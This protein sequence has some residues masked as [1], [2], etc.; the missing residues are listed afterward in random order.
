MA[1]AMREPA[2]MAAL[3][4]DAVASVLANKA[5]AQKFAD[6]AFV[7]ALHDP[8]ISSALRSEAAARA[9]SADAVRKVVTSDAMRQAVSSGLLGRALSSEAMTR[10]L[11]NDV[12][13]TRHV[14]AEVRRRARQLVLTTAGRGQTPACHRR[15]TPHTTHGTLISCWHPCEVGS[16]RHSRC[17]VSY[18]RFPP[19]PNS[20]SSPCRACN[21]CI[22]IRCRPFSCR[23]PRERFS[24]RSHFRPGLFDFHPK[25]PVLLLLTDISDSGNAAASTVPRDVV[26]VEIA[27]LSF[28]FETISGNERMNILMNHELVHIATMDQATGPDRFFRSLFGGKVVPVPEQPESILYFLLTSPRVASPRWYHEGIAVFVD[29][30]MSGGLGR[31]QSGYDEM[32]F[33]SMVRD[34]T[35][36]F[37][38]LGLVSA[39][40][41]IDFQTQVNSYLYGTRFMTW[42]GRHYSPEKVIEWVSRRDG[43][44]AYYAAQFKHVFGDSAR[45]GMGSMGP[46]GARVPAGQPRTDSHNSR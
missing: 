18:L 12:F 27:P 3:H 6:P 41:Q 39:G 28:A 26:T 44:R 42:L 15:Q 40:T 4:S 9:F 38:P 29:T 8:A 24:T 17:S 45:T 20:A 10:A 7:K 32:V 5:L 31:A 22:S 11:N 35:P 43:S 37:D 1:R 30:W 13:A 46:R 25:K 19:S 14:V 33:R 21:S 16:R 23:T 2:L 36:F 34:N